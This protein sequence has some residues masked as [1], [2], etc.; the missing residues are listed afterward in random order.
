MTDITPFN[1]VW[2]AIGDDQEEAD[3]LRLRAELIDALRRRI[4]H[5]GWRQAEAARYLGVTQPRISDLV[6]GRISRFS[7]DSLIKMAGAAGLS[8]DIAITETTV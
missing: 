8:V 2:D 4:D 1:S 6:R 7:L 3:N 5:L